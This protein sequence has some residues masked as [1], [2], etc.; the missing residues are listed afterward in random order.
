[1]TPGKV[2]NLV[3]LSVMINTVFGVTCLAE[4]VGSDFFPFHGGIMSGLSDYAHYG[5][6]IYRDRRLNFT[7]S[8]HDLVIIHGNSLKFAINIGQAVE[9]KNLFTSDAEKI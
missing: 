9:D 6:E 4:T 8:N 5:L 1:M 3:S 7:T 2:A